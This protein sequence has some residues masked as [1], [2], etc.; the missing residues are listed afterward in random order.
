MYSWF[1][2]HD[3]YIF[4]TPGPTYFVDIYY[5]V[6]LKPFDYNV[7]YPIRD[8]VKRLNYPRH[9]LKCSHPQIA[10]TGRN[11]YGFLRTVIVD[12]RESCTAECDHTN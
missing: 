12:N 1:F 9:P 3:V 4:I 7:Q 2:Q 8:Y 10:S 5:F 11:M 6:D